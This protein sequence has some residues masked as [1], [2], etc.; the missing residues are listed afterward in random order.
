MSESVRHQDGVDNLYHSVGL[1]D[2]GNNNRRHAAF[3][4]GQ[5]VLSILHGYGER[6]A[7]NRLEFSL[8]VTLL[9]QDVV[10]LKIPIAR[11]FK[12]KGVDQENFRKSSD[13]CACALGIGLV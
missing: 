8:A 11:Q 12:K 1:D 6:T 5:P 10:R 4:A 3:F 7:L 2:I 9:D 13:G